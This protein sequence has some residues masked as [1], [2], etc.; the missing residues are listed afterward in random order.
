MGHWDNHVKDQVATWNKCTAQ[1]EVIHLKVEKEKRLEKTM[2]HDNNVS[3]KTQGTC[4]YLLSD[5]DI[6]HDLN[7][8]E[9]I[10]YGLPWFKSQLIIF[11]GLR[12]NHWFS[13]LA[14]QENHLRKFLGFLFICFVFLTI[15]M[16]GPQQQKSK[17]NG[18]I[19]WGA[20]ICIF[21]KLPGWF[22]VSQGGVPLYSL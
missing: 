4:L 7:V 12:H 10:D 5:H 3:N 22:S 11:L 15:P 9:P 6:P 13:T 21:L 14:A 20:G 16:P 1:H 8:W 17:L 2:L 18:I 19:M